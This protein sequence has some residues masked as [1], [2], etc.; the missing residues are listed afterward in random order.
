VTQV[1]AEEIAKSFY[2]T[3]NLYP[4]YLGELMPL[5]ADAERRLGRDDKALEIIKMWALFMIRV[6]WLDPA[7]NRVPDQ[8]WAELNAHL[9][10]L[11]LYVQ[12]GLREKFK[13]VP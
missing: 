4:L 11:P 9:H 5:G 8:T 6:N 12:A 10:E 2:L 1:G 3:I 13:E 7:K